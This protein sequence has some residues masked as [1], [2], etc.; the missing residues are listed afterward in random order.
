VTAIRWEFSREF[1]DFALY[2]WVENS[3]SSQKGLHGTRPLPGAIGYG[4]GVEERNFLE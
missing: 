1:F 4:V 2:P 3:P